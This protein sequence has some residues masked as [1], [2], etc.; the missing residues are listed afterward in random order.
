MTGPDAPDEPS[1]A[2][3]V[4]RV[5]AY[6]VCRRGDDVL[7]VRA[8][9]RT[10]VPGTWFLP[11]GGIDFGEDPA[12]A[13]VRELEEET[14]L[15]CAAPTLLGVL[16]DVRPRRSGQRVF[17]VRLIY[18]VRGLDGEMR[19]EASG[20]SDVARWHDARSLDA[21]PLAGYVLEALAL[22]AK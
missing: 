17:S 20:T 19:H 7:L 13:V 4:V 12:D 14:G 5:G 9:E 21:L 6:A 10:E 3:Q 2:T 11:G 16:T 8:S 15:S 1:D 18:E 22:S